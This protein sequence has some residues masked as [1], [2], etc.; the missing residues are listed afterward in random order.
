VV[1]GA[2]PVRPQGLLVLT[3]LVVI[4][5][6]GGA[7]LYRNRAAKADEMIAAIHADAPSTPAGRLERWM[8]IGSVQAHH[9][10][11]KVARFSEEMPWLV[12][13]AV[14]AEQGE[15][16][17]WGIMVDELPR[18]LMH[19]E[20]L[21]AVLSLPAPRRL[22]RG[23]MAANGMAHVP[24]LRASDIGSEQGFDPS[25][26]LVELVDWFL[27]RLGGALERDVEG[28]RLEIRVVDKM[29]ES[30]IGGG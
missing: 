3:A 20:E 22:G 4:G 13:H 25:A 18:D 10:L 28:A 17:I 19:Q 12:T 6:G 23:S 2:G 14:E 5:M 11:T 29:G 1:E 9:R 15:P 7:V 16:W 27:E 8:T 21:V 26:R 24:L 30:A